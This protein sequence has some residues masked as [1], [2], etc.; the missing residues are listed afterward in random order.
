MSKRSL[1]SNVRRTHLHHNPTTMALPRTRRA[2]SQL[3]FTLESA[4][5]LRSSRWR[6]IAISGRLRSLLDMLR[7]GSIGNLITIGCF[8][9]RSLLMRSSRRL[10]RHLLAGKRSTG[11]FR[12]STGVSRSGLIRKRRRRSERIWWAPSLWFSRKSL[13]FGL[14]FESVCFCFCWVSR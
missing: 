4:R 13:L 3:E 9:M 10:L 2:V 5:T 1:S 12:K 8:W 7:I 6:G 14:L 11:W